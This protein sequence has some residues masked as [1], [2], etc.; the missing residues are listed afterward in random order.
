VVVPRRRQPALLRLRTAAR[1]PLGV[2]LTLWRYLWRLTPVQRWDAVVAL[3]PEA[4]PAL[5]A[6]TDTRELLRARDGVGPVVHRLY[7]ARIAGSALGPEELMARVT[8]DL[9]AVAPSE[10]ASFQRLSGAN[11]GLSVG[12][13]FV[14]RMPG[15]WDG[16]VRVTEVTPSSFRLATLT[17]HLEAGQIEFRTRRRDGVLEFSIESWATSGDRLSRLLYEHL[18]VAKE[19]QQHMWTSVLEAVIELSGGR[20][21]GPLTIITQ[22]AEDDN[23]EGG[24]RW[25]GRQRRLLEELHGRR[26]NFDPEADPTRERGWHV[27]DVVRSLPREPAG[28]PVPAGSWEFARRLMIEYQVADPALVRALYRRDAPLAG[29]DMLLQIR[30]LGLR[31]HVGV[32]VG[33]VYDE[34]RTVGGREVR[35]FGWGYATLEGHFEQGRLHYEV[36]K[37]LD[38]GDVEFRLHAY[39]RAADSGPLLKRLGFRLVGRVRQLEFYRRAGR[40]VQALTQAQLALEGSS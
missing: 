22:D 33:D 17:G 3:E 29:R 4:E 9:D 32:R 26:L 28:P 31:L 13:E 1:W 11:G 6:G 38:S 18:K 10:F 14:V 24:A 16:P 23:D 8:A 2:T 40:R 21:E 39:S 34:T 25:T 20:R 35:V 30:W 36:W 19:V 27:D 12:D 15:P 37:W 5:P 7:S